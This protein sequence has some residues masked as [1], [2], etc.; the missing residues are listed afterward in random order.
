M[1]IKKHTRPHGCPGGFTLVETLLA[2]GVAA[3]LLVGAFVVY[4]QV[5]H[6][7]KVRVAQDQIRIFSAGVRAAFPHG[8]YSSLSNQFALDAKII[9][10]GWKS[11]PSN[12]NSS[13]LRHPWG[14]SM[15][16]S[17][18]DKT[19]ATGVCGPAADGARCTH[20][21]MVWAGVPSHACVDLLS[22][23]GEEY[24]TIWAVHVGNDLGVDNPNLLDERG[25]P[26]V[27]RIVDAC[28][29]A[30][31]VNIRFVAR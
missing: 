15:S 14:S 2:L 1:N 5:S 20:F 11:N 21:R 9:D 18:T 23:V 8:D 13:S 28:N 6:A 3:I 26:D 27:A 10:S 25:Q 16:V 4:T 19:T 29:F 12:P 22:G 7:S 24:E 17:G 31:A 30:E